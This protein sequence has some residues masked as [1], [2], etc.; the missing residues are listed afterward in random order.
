MIIEVTGIRSKTEFVAL[1]KVKDPDDNVRAADIWMQ[2]DGVFDPRLGEV[3]I[4]PHIR[5]PVK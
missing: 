2:A 1:T 4:N 3:R 5:T